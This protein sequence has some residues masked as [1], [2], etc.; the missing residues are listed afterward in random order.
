MGLDE[1]VVRRLFKGRALKAAKLPEVL[2]TYQDVS[3]A[4]IMSHELVDQ[5]ETFARENAEIEIDCDAF[6]S[7]LRSLHEN[8]SDRSRED[9]D[10][11]LDNSFHGG[12]ITPDTTFEM[13][14]H[15]S[16]KTKGIPRSAF[17]ERDIASIRAHDDR[18]DERRSV[19]IRK[20]AQ[21]NDALERLQAEHDALI[22]L[23]D[24]QEKT[25]LSLQKQ[26]KQLRRELH[27]ASTREQSQTAEIHLLRTQLTESEAKSQ[28][29]KRQAALSKTELEAKQEV[30]LALEN[31][32]EEQEEEVVQWRK[33]CQHQINETNDLIET[34]TTQRSAINKLEQTIETIEQTHAATERLRSQYTAFH[35]MCS[36]LNC[37]TDKRLEAMRPTRPQS[38]TR[39]S[40]RYRPRS[41]SD[42]CLHISRKP[43]RSTEA[44]QPRLVAWTKPSSASPSNEIPANVTNKI[45]TPISMQNEHSFDL[46]SASSHAHDAS[47]W[48]WLLPIGLVLLG[49]WAGIWAHW[50]ALQFSTASPLHWIQ[51]NTPNDPVLLAEIY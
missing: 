45:G 17:S 16:P 1:S 35:A 8:D 28:L 34:C 26:D 30:I 37:E 40:L 6:L 13:D 5:V 3:G 38:S 2:Q 14:I 41:N 39:D 24:E 31:R 44:Y 27:D 10:S 20:L 43:E 46:V 36:A 50:L 25:Q 11:M 21:V 29:S 22:V 32:A 49:I 42:S 4:M 23:K 48:Y 47:A 9:L 33:R 15:S 19:L 18:H 7:M 51:A 12:S